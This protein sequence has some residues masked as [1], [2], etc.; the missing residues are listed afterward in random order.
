MNS[1]S[2]GLRQRIGSRQGPQQD[3][4]LVAAETAAYIGLDERSRKPTTIALR[5]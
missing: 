3:A 4:E 5:T 1:K 2:S